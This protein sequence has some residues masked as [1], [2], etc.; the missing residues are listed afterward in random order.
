MFSKIG[1]SLWKLTVEQ[2]DNTDKYT[3]E[4]IS[5]TILTRIRLEHRYNEKNPSTR[6]K[7]ENARD[8]SRYLP[9]TVS[10]S[11]NSSDGSLFIKFVKP[12]ALA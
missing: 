7:I 2:F 6:K 8:R 10:V 4:G 9:F 12:I 3:Y 5:E 1:T 11:K